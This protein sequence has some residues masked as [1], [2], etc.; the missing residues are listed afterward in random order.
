MA[1]WWWKALIIGGAG[2]LLGGLLGVGGGIVMI[3]LLLYLM[4]F[5]MH[6]AKAL[7]LAIIIIVGVSG[8]VEHARQGHLKGMLWFVILSGLA[9]VA[10]SALGARC[11][12]HLKGDT[13]KRIF[14]V[15]L[16]ATAVQM[17]LP[18]KPA[19][20]GQPALDRPAAEAGQ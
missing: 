19:A 11:S 13:L 3:P 20:E 7:S 8:T 18:K 17:L 16:I 15:L 10:C 12:A 4:R 2:G 6:A 14:A 9:A 5:E 1:D